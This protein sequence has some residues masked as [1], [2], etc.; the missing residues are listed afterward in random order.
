MLPQVNWRKPRNERRL[1]VS[2][3]AKEP[4]SERAPERAKSEVGK[5]ET[6]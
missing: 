4:L 6:R 5:T 2:T 1:Q 3:A